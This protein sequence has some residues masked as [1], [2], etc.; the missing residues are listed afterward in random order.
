MSI[1]NNNFNTKAEKNEISI[2]SI[3]KLL[4]LN[5]LSVILITTVFSI[6]SLTYGF[7]APKYY[8]SQ[9]IL[10]IQGQSSLNSSIG[11]LG[12]IAQIAGINI[13]P[14]N[15]DK[16]Y[17]AIKTIESRDFLRHLI[18]FEGV[19]PSLMAVKGYDDVTKKI[20]Y[21]SELYDEA[22][23]SWKQNE[24]TKLSLQPSY[25]KSY[26]KYLKTVGIT[27][28]PLT[29]LIRLTVEH[30]SPQFAKE[31]SDLI[32]KESNE[33][34]RGKDLKESSDAIDFLVSEIPK[35]SLVTM[36][37]AINQL[38]LSKL[39][40]QMMAKISNEY[41]LEIV[42]PPFV[43]EKK[44]RPNRTL[45]LF[46]GTFFGFAFSSALVIANYFFRGKKR[47]I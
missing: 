10:K 35:S 20:I 7:F 18:A 4:F 14:D 34:L 42:D 13:Q 28:D 37:D 41:V 27:Q 5:K 23:N 25:L 9:S 43:P 2:N 47:L 46:L 21:D 31:F 44:S 30:V 15:E 32:I 12:G 11:T 29:S 6:V 22:K 33:L 17:L 19:L 8:I 38:V 45:I 40:T 36:K 24:V 1:N 16:T 3:L 39:E 26:D